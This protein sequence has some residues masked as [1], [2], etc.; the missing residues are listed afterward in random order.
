MCPDCPIQARSG[1]RA[2]R[3]R[4]AMRSRIRVQRGVSSSGH[5]TPG[6]GSNPERRALFPFQEGLTAFICAQALAPDFSFR[7]HKGGG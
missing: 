5:K 7:I 6:P 1:S 3:L 2:P 4:F